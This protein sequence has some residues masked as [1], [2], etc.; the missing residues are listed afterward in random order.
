VRLA[1]TND[2]LNYGELAAE[3]AQLD[4]EEIVTLKSPAQFRLIGR[5]MRRLD[6]A[7]MVDGSRQ[8]SGDVTLPGLLTATV[9]HSPQP[10]AT[11]KSIDDRA[12]RA[13]RGFRGVVDLGDGVAVVADDTWSA[14][15]AERALDVRW[16]APA[17]PAPDTEAM[18]ELLTQACRKPAKPW[19]S[20][21]DASLP[22][23]ADAEDA[24]EYALPFEAHAPME[25]A[26][27]V[28]D[29]RAHSCEVW[30][31]SQSPWLVYGTAAMHGLWGRPGA[32]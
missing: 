16:Q 1:G 29:V 31:P 14:L 25:T 18:R 17:T 27:C 6:G 11:V 23:D 21:G 12:A 5:E 32:L 8:Y 30:A 26:T 3:A 19:F 24:R 15:K 20:R 13:V 4:V 2:A 9:R 28:A 7:Q 22:A 10:G